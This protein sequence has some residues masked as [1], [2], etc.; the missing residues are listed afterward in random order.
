MKR[1]TRR[2]NRTLRFEGLEARQ[3]LAADTVVPLVGDWDGN[4]FDTLGYY[5][6]EEGT[7]LVSNSNESGFA[8][9]SARF[10]PKDSQLT[11][12][13]GDW[14]GDNVD[15]L[16][17]YDAAGGKFFLKN[18]MEAGPAD[19]TFGFGPKGQDWIPIAGD[20]NNDGSD[21]VGL[22]FQQ[23]GKAFLKDTQTPGIADEVFRYGPKNDNWL[24][25][26]G[27][28]DNDGED[29][30]GL[31][32]PDNGE[33]FLRNSHTAGAANEKFSFG[34]LG[35]VIP[36]VGD[37]D[38]DTVIT[39]GIYEQSTGKTLV[40]NTRTPGPADLEIFVSPFVG[41]NPQVQP[42]VSD[43]FITASDVE[44]LLERAAAASASEDAIIAV[45]DRGGN[46]LGVRVE[47]DVLTAIPDTETLVF[48]IDGAV[49]KARTAAFF[50][51]DPVPLTSRLIR[52]ISQSTITQREVESNP[53]VCNPAD[54]AFDPL[55]C[56]PGF[57]APIGLGGHFPP[58]ID[59][60]P[61]VDLFAIEHTNRDSSIH[62]GPD[63]IKGTADDIPLMERFNVD[64][65]FI[66]ATIPAASKLA[67]PDSY[68]TASG[69]LPSA[70]SRGI[71][72][73][74]GGIPLHK[75]V[76]GDGRAETLVGGIGVFFP[77][78][79]GFATH[80]QGFVPGIGQSAGAR[81]NASRVLESEW[82]AF[83]TAGGTIDHPV[84]TLNT[85][86][87]VADFQIP[88]VESNRLTLVGIELEIIG[89]H[90]DG[91]WTI[92]AVGDAVTGFDVTAG[93]SGADQIV[94]PAM[95]LYL[96][97][98]PVPEGWLVLPH[99]SP[100]GDM[101]AEQVKEIIERGIDEANKVRAAVR[102]PLSSRTKM[103]LSV[104]DTEG[105]VLGLFRMDDATVF[106]LDVAVA[107][108]RNA[109]YYADPLA[110]KD[111]D[112]VDEDVPRDG[113]PDVAAGVAMTAR[114][115][116]YLAEPRFPDGVEG[117]PSGPFSLLNDPGTNPVTAENS[118]A[119][120]APA[121]FVVHTDASASVLGYDAFRP[122]SNFRDDENVGSADFANK[123]GI[124]FFPGSSPLYRDDGTVIGGLGIS[125]DGVDQD[126]VVTFFATGG[127]LPPAS[128]A[129]A[130]EIAVRGVRLP[131]M[132]FLRNPEGG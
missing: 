9:L 31:Y 78:P 98:A 40:R 33:F 95:A 27:D 92:M 61:V 25:V 5:R 123:N 32:D 21:S 70:Q 50:G 8:E 57:V 20:W 110:I 53:N 116:R 86:P 29:T 99:D 4:G 83:A 121:S 37:F 65:T 130:D 84:G 125:G 128:V 126:D 72:T 79:D 97:G 132:K 113:I 131:F 88:I 23:G 63:L 102:L 12:I 6:A 16:G 55:V 107:K 56:G 36:L 44:K 67:A 108:A 60:T 124:V 46:I 64:P 71:A 85:I 101:T 59:H 10:G 43:P 91:L 58:G 1:K 129:R 120:F 19:V 48:A 66:P 100:I 18:D 47:A 34:S 11:P 118:A 111:I 52:F 28:W 106:S 82:I 13:V 115:F 81:T 89:P 39:A 17:L 30:L 2:T 26:V 77:G 22:Y 119:G 74:P 76:D 38:M 105:N 117:T 114:T 54:V 90:P 127:F 15:S 109:A 103:I 3:M 87:P 62:P 94:N 49:S 93:A 69:R 80:E 75:D 122:G 112:R 96:D 73:L 14:D 35:G 7:L 51:N 45:V 68:G 41:E 24:P 104:A 42:Q